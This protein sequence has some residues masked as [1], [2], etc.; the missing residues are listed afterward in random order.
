[1]TKDSP[2]LERRFNGELFFYVD[3]FSTK[4]EAQKLQFEEQQKGSRTRLVKSYGY[5]VVYRR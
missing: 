5:W 3:A 4:P 2:K 1:M